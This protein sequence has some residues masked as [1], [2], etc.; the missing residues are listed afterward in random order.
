MLLLGHTAPTPYRQL[1]QEDRVVEWATVWLFLAAGILGARRA[2][3]DR[4]LF[5]GLVALFC[6]FVAGE[7]FSWGQ[8]LLG[9]YPP[10]FFLGNNFQQEFNV[11]NLPQS[12]LQPKWVLMAALG[13]YGV[14]LPAL[15]RME[16]PRVLMRRVGVTAPP[17]DV[18]PWFT[19]AMALLVWYPLTL[20]GEWVELFTGALFLVSMRPAPRTFWVL[21][22]SGPLVGAA[23]TLATDSLEHERNAGRRVCA[24]AEAQRL[25]EDIASGHAGT[26]QLWQMNRV[27]KRIWSSVNDSYLDAGKLRTFHGICADA[28]TDQLALRHKYGLDPWGSPYW[29]VVDTIADNDRRVTVYS[30]GPNRRRDIDPTGDDIVATSIRH[31]KLDA[32]PTIPN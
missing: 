11:H 9:F 29:L 10:E 24:T 3:T 26:Q 25:L 15:S 4:R 16:R 30:F 22:A 5:I 14:L 21:L 27:H 7:E 13:G 28:G 2:I 8:R 12:F 6:L 19:A 1:L 31:V 18:V 32:P 17:V 23:L 20:T